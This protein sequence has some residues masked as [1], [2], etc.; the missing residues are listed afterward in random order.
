VAVKIPISKLEQE[1]GRMIDRRFKKTIRQWQFDTIKYLKR[2]IPATIQSGNTPV[3]GGKFKKTYS[4]SY[5]KQIRAGRFPG[6]RLRPVNLTVTGKMLRSLKSRRTKSGISMFFSSGI[7]KYHDRLGAGKSR[8]IRRML[9]RGNEEFIFKI[10]NKVR[11]IF[12][13]AF[14]LAFK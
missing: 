11:N 2:E 3:Q 6:K 9:P 4:D 12:A 13:K 14:R 1:V 8:V 10:R 7:A 5:K